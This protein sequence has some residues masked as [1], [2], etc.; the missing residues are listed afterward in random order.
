MYEVE[1]EAPRRSG[2]LL[3]LVPLGVGALVSVALGRYGA[4]HQP[5]GYAVGLAGFSGALPMKA[6]LT[7]GAALLAGVQILSAMVMWGKIQLDAPWIE[8]VHRWSGRLAF[9][10]TLPVAFHCLYA[11]GARYDNPRVMVH[12]IAG[13]FF[14]GI[15]ITK[16]L[17]LPRR[18]VPAW[19]F[20]ILGGLL[21]TALVA[22]WVT[23][24]LWFFTTSG[25]KW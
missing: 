5:T 11:L 14:Y 7:T 25:L 9:L 1:T 23:S 2:A 6:W 22:L 10:M 20:A 24:S 16:M 12:S 17:S 8:G 13:C 4:V 15:F 3:L 18:G 19:A 21:F